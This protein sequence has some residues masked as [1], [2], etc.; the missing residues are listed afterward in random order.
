MSKERVAIDR[1]IQVGTANGVNIVCLYNLEDNHEATRNC[2]N[3]LQMEP[4]ASRAEVRELRERQAIQERQMFETECQL[5]KFKAE[6]N[7][8]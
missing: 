6:F 7:K 2:T 8:N 1:V 3:L 4:A 5:A